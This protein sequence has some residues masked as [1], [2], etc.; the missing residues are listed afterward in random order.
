MPNYFRGTLSFLILSLFV[1]APPRA[2]A[3]KVLSTVNFLQ[4][5]SLTLM[6]G[7]PHTAES[8]MGPGVDPHLYR[9]SG[10]DL[11]RIRQADY[12]LAIG[13]HLEGKIQETLKDLS[14]R[15]KIVF[16][17]E[18]LPPETLL[19]IEGSTTNHDP[20]VWFDPDNWKKITQHLAAYFSKEDPSH[21]NLYEKNASSFLSRLDIE[22]AA[23]K[24]LIQTL[25]RDRRILITSHDAFRYFGRAF[26]FEVHGI[27]GVSTDSEIGIKRLEDLAIL[28]RK[29]KLR[30]IFI[31]NS[32]PP[33]TI[34]GLRRASQC[35]VGGQL[36]GDSLGD[37]GTPAGEYLGMLRHNV[38]TIVK[39]LK[40]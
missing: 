21:K 29:R 7:T 5:L 6:K 38:E 4:D 23:L 20:H 26:D 11:S 13:I 33:S 14:K 36:F 37:L 22:V 18:I 8:L 24:K 40:P 9:M 39:G 35:E 34:E 19:P 12:V 17:G 27:Q 1:G 3:F 15:K 16:L 2:Q 30:S 25:P 31:E 32:V 10:G 28:I